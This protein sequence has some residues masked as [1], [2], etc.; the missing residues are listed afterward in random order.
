M[1]TPRPERRP[2]K[3]TKEACEKGKY[4]GPRRFNGELRDIATQALG[5][6]ITQKALRA[7]VGRGLIPYRRLGGRIVFLHDEVREFLHQLPGV[8]AADALANVAA[9]N[10]A[11]GAAR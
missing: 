9:R 6:G 4:C 2:P 3:K 1:T 7:Q 11:S 5:L 10:G 8:T